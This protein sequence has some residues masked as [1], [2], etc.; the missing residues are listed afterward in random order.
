MKC[1]QNENIVNTMCFFWEVISNGRVLEKIQKDN[2]IW[3]SAT[4]SVIRT[5]KKKKAFS[6]I[7]GKSHLCPLFPFLL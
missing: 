3:K 2:Q 1:S 7:E 5:K 4:A 6:A